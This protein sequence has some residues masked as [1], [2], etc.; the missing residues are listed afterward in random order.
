MG[1]RLNTMIP[2]DPDDRMFAEFHFIHPKTGVYFSSHGGWLYDDPSVRES[3]YF[4]YF[5]E[6]EV[7]SITTS[8]LVEISYLK[9]GKLQL[10]DGNSVY[11]LNIHGKRIF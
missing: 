11:L 4:F 8:P 7:V 10:F 3:F 6:G 5:M 2:S 9:A 1:E